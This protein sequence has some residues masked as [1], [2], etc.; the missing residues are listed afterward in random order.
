MPAL[1]SL[2]LGYSVC[3]GTNASALQLSGCKTAGVGPLQPCDFLWLKLMSHPDYSYQGD[4]GTD[5][6]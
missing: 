6:G 2:I 5:S 4:P 3:S 1:E